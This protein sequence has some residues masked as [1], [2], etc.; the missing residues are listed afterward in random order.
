MSQMARQALVS[1]CV[2]FIS[3]YAS[4]QSGKPAAPE[5][6]GAVYLLNG[7]DQSLRMLP[8]ETARPVSAKDG[9]VHV[10]GRLVRH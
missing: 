8:K 5:L 9:W 6:R 3:S 4:G 10:D 2:F 1:I 7:V